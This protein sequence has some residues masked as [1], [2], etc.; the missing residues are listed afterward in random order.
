MPICAGARTLQGLNPRLPASRAASPAAKFRIRLF[1]GAFARHRD[2]HSGRLRKRRSFK[3]QTGPA[4]ASPCASAQ[5]ISAHGST[6]TSSFVAPDLY[7]SSVVT[8]AQMVPTR[9]Q[10]TARLGVASACLGRPRPGIFGLRGRVHSFHC[11]QCPLSRRNM[12]RQVVAIVDRAM[13]SATTTI[14]ICSHKGCQF[15]E[16]QIQSGVPRAAGL[17]RRQLRCRAASSAAHP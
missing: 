5:K 4:N 14:V 13:R 2:R 17:R 1:P 6:Q 9:D 10:S 8:V 11:F 15:L 12:S 16:R 7:E 3:C